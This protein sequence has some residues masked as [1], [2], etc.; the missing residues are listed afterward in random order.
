MQKHDPFGFCR[1]C[2]SA[3]L[4]IIKQDE[5]RKQWECQDCGRQFSEIKYPTPRH[6]SE[7]ITSDLKDGSSLIYEKE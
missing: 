6:D 3:N 2:G 1:S 4:K 5:N 7:F